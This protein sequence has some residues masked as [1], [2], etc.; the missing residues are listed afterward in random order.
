VD[1]VEQMNNSLIDVR[2]YERGVEDETGACGT[3]S[4]ASAIV[5]Y[6]K[7]NPAVRNNKNAKMRVRTSGKEILEVTFHINNGQVS[8]VWLKGSA[9]FIAQGEYYV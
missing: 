8:N 5:T 1:F 7:S 6:L 4:V 9:N 2:T 3:G